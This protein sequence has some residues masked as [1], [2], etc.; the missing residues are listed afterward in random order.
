MAGHP[1]G[2]AIPG[3][4]T[5]LDSHAL[6]INLAGSP[7][8]KTSTSENP[9]PRAT[10]TLWK[11]TRRQPAPEKPAPWRPV[12]IARKVGPRR[13][14]LRMAD[15]RMVDQVWSISPII[16]APSSRWS[17]AM[18]LSSSTSALASLSGSTSS[19]SGPRCRPGIASGHPPEPPPCRDAGTRGPACAA[20]WAA[21]FAADRAAA[22]PGLGVRAACAEPEDRLVPCVGLGM[23]GMPGSG[24]SGACGQD[25]SVVSRS[26]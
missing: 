21:A 26:R 25:S 19:D 3:I 11:P 10:S 6:G 17:K 15:P 24:S 16:W 1:N 18:P 13:L 20:A 14:V 23:G 9:T 4:P 22:R 2:R 12:P 5:R 8:L 7:T